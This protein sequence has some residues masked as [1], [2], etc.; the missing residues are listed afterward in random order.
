MSASQISNNAS[1]AVDGARAMREAASQL[2]AEAQ[3][4][5]ARASLFIEAIRPG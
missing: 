5:D 1:A 4:L 2:A 3:R